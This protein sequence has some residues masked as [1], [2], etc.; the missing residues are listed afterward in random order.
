MRALKDI[1]GLKFPDDYVIKHFYKAGLHNRTG[2]VLEVGCAGGNNLMLYADYGWQVTGVDILP[3]ALAQARHN[4]GPDAHLIEASGDDG[5]PAGITTPV[6]V[7]LLPNVLCYLRDDGVA[8]L[9]QAVRDHAAPGAE[10][11]VRTRLIDDYR[12][13]RGAPAGRDNFILDTPET[14]EAG[15]FHRFYSRAALIDLVT[16]AFGVADPTVFH[17][18]FDN[19]QA[20]RLIEN[21]SDL[22]IWGKMA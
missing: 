2:H 18:R 7:V 11:F 4:L 8:A 21:N 9:A 17:I 14:G 16:G 19:H 1:Q 20:G 5:L 10:I 6:D 13:G 12:Y 3:D 22:V 15:L